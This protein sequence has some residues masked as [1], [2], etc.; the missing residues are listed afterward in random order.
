MTSHI[1]SLAP[2]PHQRSLDPCILGRYLV[3]LLAENTPEIPD[4][5]LIEKAGPL[6]RVKKRVLSKWSGTVPPTR[7]GVCH[8]SVVTSGRSSPPKVPLCQRNGTA[9][10]G[11]RW[12]S[13]VVSGSKPICPS[14]ARL[15][16]V[17]CT[18][19]THSGSGMPG[20]GH[21]QATR[22]FSNGRGRVKVS[23]VLPLSSMPSEEGLRRLSV[24]NPSNAL[25]AASE[26]S[27]AHLS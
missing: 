2:R 5:S 26:D 14:I 13:V 11:S 3:A 1:I 8:I 18:R 22:K 20:A 7:R 17:S 25:L 12:G 6:L 16:S 21:S 27:Y 4:K 24:Y 15:T 23:E 19:V 9:R 10:R